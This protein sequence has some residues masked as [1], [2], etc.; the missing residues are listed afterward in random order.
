MVF[1]VTDPFDNMDQQT[2]RSASL[3]SLRRIDHNRQ[4]FLETCPN[5]PHLDDASDEQ[6][7]LH[8][9]AQLMGGFILGRG[10]MLPGTDPAQFLESLSGKTSEAKTERAGLFSRLFTNAG[11]GPDPELRD[12]MIPVLATWPGFDRGAYLAGE[13]QAEEFMA[14]FAIDFPALRELAFEATKPWRLGGE[15]ESHPDLLDPILLSY[16]GAAFAG[17]ES[18]KLEAFMEEAVARLDDQD[19]DLEPVM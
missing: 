17:I 12:R 7:R 1:P 16:Q 4:Q 13:P 19:R 9:G 10:R 6:R 18:D 15:L 3:A 2:L 11:K 5:R 8:F 14:E